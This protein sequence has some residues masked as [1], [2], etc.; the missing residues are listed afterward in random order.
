MNGHSVG[1]IGPQESEGLVV[2]ELK[3]GSCS[4][5]LVAG[6]FNFDLVLV[7]TAFHVFEFGGCMNTIFLWIE[8]I[9]LSLEILQQKLINYL[10]GIVRQIDTIAKCILLE[11]LE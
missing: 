10:F 1:D 3:G 11:T 5:N 6:G 8:L 4:W 7:E 9:A 2:L